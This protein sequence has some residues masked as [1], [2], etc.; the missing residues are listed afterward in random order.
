MGQN[1][2]LY[3]TGEADNRTESG[4]RQV[5]MAGDRMVSWATALNVRFFVFFEGRLS[6]KEP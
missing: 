3:T 6:A 4:G 1:R 2:L 5:R